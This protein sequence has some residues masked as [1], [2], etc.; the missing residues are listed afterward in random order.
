MCVSTRNLYSDPRKQ[1][2]LLAHSADLLREQAVVLDRASELHPVPLANE[3]D[4]LQG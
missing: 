2:L 1:A 3:E 4:S